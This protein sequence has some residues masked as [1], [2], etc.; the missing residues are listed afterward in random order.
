MLKYLD[1]NLILNYMIEDLLEGKILDEETLRNA[2]KLGSFDPL[3]TRKIHDLGRFGLGLKTASFSQA[4]KIIVA[5]KQ[6]NNIYAR[7]WDLDYV[8]KEEKWEIEVLN[9][10]LESI[11]EIKQ[12]EAIHTGTLVL[13]EKLDKIIVK[14]NSNRF[15]YFQYFSF[16]YILF[17][18]FRRGYL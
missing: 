1:K 4:S 8:T 9:N 12:L 3:G 13:W 10:K 6:N 2:M 15:K 11:H 18:S 5:S 16:K 7:C 17:L 14:F